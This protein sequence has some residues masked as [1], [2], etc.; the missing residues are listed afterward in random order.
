MDKTINPI[1]IEEQSLGEEEIEAIRKV[2]QSTWLSHGETVNRFEEK[3][4]SLYSINN[5]IAVSSCSIALELILKS[6][7][8]KGKKSKAALPSLN[9]YAC[10]NSVLNAGVEPVIVDVDF[11]TLNLSP[12]KVQEIMGDDI[13]FIIPIHYS[14]IPAD[15]SA[16]ASIASMHNAIIVEDA[17]H[18][19]HSQYKGKY[20]GSHGNPTCFSFDS[21]KYITTGEGGVII[22]TYEEIDEKEIRSIICYGVQHKKVEGTFELLKILNDQKAY[23]IGTNYK[24]SD[25]NAAIGLVQL[26]KINNFYEKR[27]KIGKIYLD[28]LAILESEGLIKIFSRNTPT[29]DI[30]YYL[31]VVWIDFSKLRITKKELMEELYREK[32]GFGIHYYPLHRHPIYE[33]YRIKDEEYQNTEKLYKG[34]ID[35]PIS[36]NMTSDE[37]KFVTNVFKKLVTSYKK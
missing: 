21:H 14:G 6:L 32:I 15:L 29:T 26:E 23:Y 12:S 3:I 22:W 27:K 4:K 33:K 24:L 34:I 7:N 10:I 9:Y 35:L 28:R 13:Q 5:V 11:E 20:I 8:K 2:F 1:Y 36:V 31:F 30:N 37:A 19:L 18:A 25:I 17:A 16:L